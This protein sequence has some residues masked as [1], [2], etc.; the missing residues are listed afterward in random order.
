MAS[1]AP[2]F[3]HKNEGHDRAASSM[4]NVKAPELSKFNSVIQNDLVKELLPEPTN[5]AKTKNSRKTKKFRISELWSSFD[6]CKNLG[7]I[8]TDWQQ[9]IKQKNPIDQLKG[10]CLFSVFMYKKQHFRLCNTHFLKLYEQLK[11]LGSKS[12]IIFILVNQFWKARISFVSLLQFVRN[13]WE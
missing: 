1:I 13:N 12:A 7:A 9:E 3:K 6:S 8:S 10:M 4:F 2:S 5:L 11:M